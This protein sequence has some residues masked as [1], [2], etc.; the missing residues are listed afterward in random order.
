MTSRPASSRSPRRARSSTP[1][2]PFV[3]PFGPTVETQKALGSGFVIDKAGHI[4]TNDHVIAG[5]KSVQVSFSNNESYKATIV[6]A[7]P[8]T[9]LAVLQ[10]N[11]SS[12]AL[13]PLVLG[14]SD[15]RP[16]RRRGRRDRRTLRPLAHRHGRDR[17]RAAASDPLA[18]PLHD[19]PRDPDRRSHQPR[20]LRRP[21][22]RPAGSRHRRQ[23]ADRHGKHGERATSASASRSPRTPCRRSIGQILKT[24]V[25]EHPFL[26]IEPE[27]ITPVLAR[28]LHLPVVSGMIVAKVDPGSG[29]A[30]SG[31]RAARRR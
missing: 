21:A 6:G 31:S 10:V 26:G 5:A 7:D 17:Q 22:D 16:G 29:A 30:R 27:T 4:V 1:A 2:D 15:Q 3:N 18:E 12:R 20:Q 11:A 24:S 13:T 14:D 8:T 19:R 23:R 9:D 28:L 25:A